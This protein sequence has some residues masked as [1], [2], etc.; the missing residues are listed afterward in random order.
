MAHVNELF[1][2]VERWKKM[3]RS[4]KMVWPWQ[5]WFED[6]ANFISI[7][8]NSALDRFLADADGQAVVILKH[9]ST[10]GVSSRAYGEMSSFEGSVGLITVQEA[11]DVS[12]EIERRTGVP[13]ETPQILILHNDEVVFNAS[14]FQVKA[15]TVKKELNRL[16]GDG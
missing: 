5:V 10:C 15:E 8:D 11:R 12:N 7:E 13:H 3:G 6:M 1:R 9:S 16:N 14:H 2:P 4:A